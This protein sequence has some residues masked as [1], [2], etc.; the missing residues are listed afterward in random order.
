MKFKKILDLTQP[1]F[2]NM[3][4]PPAFPL[5]KNNI[6]NIQVEDGFNME[7]L[8]F[9]THCGTHIDAPYH[10]INSGRTLSD[11]S[12]NDLVGD[13]IILDFRGKKNDENISGIDLMKYDNRIK[14]GSIVILYTG[15]CEKRGFNEDYI[16]YP[17]WL[18]LSGAK[19][20]VQKKVK[21]IG[22]DHFSLSGTTK[23]RSFPIHIEILSNDIWIL[24][25]LR[26]TEELLAE[27]VWTLIVMPMLIKN[28]TGAPT[29]VFAIK[30]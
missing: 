12:P 24:E 2:H 29:R 18:D 8:D 3:P 14:Q 25:D 20:L 5:F 6:V 10:F 22:I 9:V 28:G 11:L 15:F 19:Y 13:A 7:K 23:E 21:G 17:I 4:G 30:Y 1:F 26:L 16:K 27:P